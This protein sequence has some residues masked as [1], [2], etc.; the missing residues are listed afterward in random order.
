MRPSDVVEL[1]ILAALWGGSFLFMR[2]G[3][4]EFGPI[5]LIALRVGLAALALAPLMWAQG[6][7]GRCRGHGRAIWVVGLT[8]SAIPFCLLAYATL[9]VTAGYA[10]ILNA[11]VPL[12]TA[13]IAFL[14][15]G[16]RLS[17]PR[18]LGLVVGFAGVGVLV[19]GRSG[20]QDG[21]AGA[22]FVAALGATFCYGLAA[23]YTRR[24]LTGVPPLA[25]AGGSQVTAALALAPLAVWLW[26]EGVISGRA[27]GALVIMALAS[28]ALAYVLYFRL[29]A[30][31]GPTRAVAVTYL[32]PLF[33]VI[34]GALLLDEM[35]TL[36]MVAGGAVILLGTGL[37]TGLIGSRAK[38]DQAAGNSPSR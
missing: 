27:W 24:H 16:E 35:V 33:G 6:G 29:L 25:V 9:S 1:L 2:I 7:W 28:T 37:T 17:W 8:N 21:G 11:T 18:I 34:W 5:P 13:L 10:S 15:L 36:P 38:P 20:F 4:P 30:R 14:W 19:A 26:P 32:I 31:V 22:A 12:W 23:N 3:A